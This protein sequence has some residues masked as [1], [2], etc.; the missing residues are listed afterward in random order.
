MILEERAVTLAHWELGYILLDHQG[1]FAFEE[2][3][4]EEGGGRRME[5]EEGESLLLRRRRE[6]KHTCRVGRWGGGEEGGGEGEREER[7]GW[8]R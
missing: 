7:K 3:K 6:E 1:W 4:G 2:G 8:M 5:M